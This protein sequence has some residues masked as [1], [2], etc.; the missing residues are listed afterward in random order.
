MSPAVCFPKVCCALRA[1]RRLCFNRRTVNLAKQCGCTGFIATQLVKQLLEKGYDVRGTVRSTHATE[2]NAP[3]LALGAALPGRLTLMEANLL[4]D[5]SFDEVVK[6]ATYV[7]H[8]ASPVILGSL[9]DPQRDL[10]SPL[11]APG[12]GTAGSVGVNI[13][14]T[15]GTVG[16]QVDP[17]VKGTTTVLESV[18]KNLDTVKKVILTSSMAGDV[19]VLLLAADARMIVGCI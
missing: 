17:A 19:P 11:L 13:G 16:T 1:S 18:A 4:Q 9:T 5:G 10:V 6:G 2:K 3:L 12:G 7:F 14:V 8:T 15:E